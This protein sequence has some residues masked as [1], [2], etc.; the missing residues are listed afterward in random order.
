MP[1]RSKG[2]RLWLE[3][4]RRDKRGRV[5]RRAVF[6]IR[7]GSI[8]R[9]TGFGKTEIEKA[10][11]ALADYQIAKYSAP[12][13]HDRDPGSVKIADVISIYAD[14]VAPRHTRPKETAGRLERLLEF[15]GNESLIYINKRTC[16]AYASQ[17][18]SDA[19]ARRELED[20]RAAIRY[21]WQN[22]Y[23]TALTP[24]MLPDR[25]PGRERWLTRSEAARLL[26][27]AWRLRQPQHGHL[28]ERPTARHVARF[29]LVALYT[30]TRA[31]AICS[32]GLDPTQ[33]RGWI[34]L[35][36]GVFY[37]RPVGG[38]ETK[39]RQPPVRLPTRLLA[40]LRR[41]ERLGSA[42]RAI[43]EWNGQPVR[44]INKAFR[45]A[46]EAAGLGPDTCATWLAQSGVP[47]W[48]AAGFMGMT[49]EM[50]ERGYG[51][52]HPDYQREASEAVSNAARQ[53]RDRYRATKREQTPLN[54]IKIADKR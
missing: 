37:R 36:H 21:H 7:D 25:N 3:P 47:V 5:I 30:G 17:R 52:H 12:R 9:S 1:R 22:G 2:A 29:I 54:V 34:D 20:L 46:R 24:V 26:W 35:D 49:A 16:G 10:Q 42:S 41:W 19:A 39:K 44:K 31:G 33:G 4:Q 48:E 13:V 18:S 14:D 28:T 50:F 11:R 45:S 8:K 15:F 38:R 53:K 32:A 51:H 40:H 23:C 6:V 43:V 27:A